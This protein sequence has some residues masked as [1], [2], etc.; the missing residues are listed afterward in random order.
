MS[1]IKMVVTD[2][3]GTLL[4]DDKHIT[5]W[6]ESIIEKLGKSGIVFAIATARPIR[7]VK[8]F[9][10]WI[11]YDA[12]VFH[13]G[14]VV[15]DGA[16]IYTD[17]GIY[18]PVDI[19]TKMLRDIPSLK[20]AVEANDSMYSNFDAE[21]L[22]PGVTSFFTKD[23]IETDKLYADKII[24]EAHT[25][26]EVELLK[27]Y[28]NDELYI[29]LSENQIA[30]IMN[31]KATKTNGIK[32]LA[33]A[34]NISM[35]QIV[36]FGDD[37]NDI[38]MLQS[39]GIG[40]AVGNA[41]EDVKKIADQICLS[42]NEDGVA[43]W[44]EEKM[45]M[46]KINRED[47]LELT[48]RMTLKRHCFGRV[49]GGYFDENGFLEGSFNTQFRKLSMVEQDRLLKVAKAIP[50]GEPN[51]LLKEHSFSPEEKKSIVWRSLMEL[52]RCEL[53]N[54]TLLENIYEMLAGRLTMEQPCGVYFFQGAYDIP[55]KGTDNQQ[56]W[57]S[58]EVYKFLICAVCP[59]GEEYVP[60]VPQEGFLF[61]AFVNRESNE[62]RINMYQKDASIE[63]GGLLYLFWD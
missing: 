52:N 9:L 6:T 24:V 26:E 17:F 21:E 34:R 14:A 39:V 25:L 20:I 38:D 37:Y 28:I 45:I 16:D 10:P 53:K 48:R 41:L 19:I 3:D 47:M 51:V 1:D 13:N 46:S 57:E 4:K 7:A 54:D 60:G 44:I 30:M 8:D 40:V 43:N 18:Q 2:L 5:A 11:K 15:M 31:K 61:P 42:N 12:A 36:A 55:L 58:E 56:Q 50:F 22:W 63:D 23:F 33:E 27:Q 49:A 59:I 32:R 35:E 62:N 29:Q